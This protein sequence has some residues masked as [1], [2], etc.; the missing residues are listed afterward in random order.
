MKPATGKERKLLVKLPSVALQDVKNR[1]PADSVPFRK[2]LDAHSSR[3]VFSPYLRGEFRGKLCP[4]IRNANRAVCSVFSG[5]I[6][7]VLNVSPQKVVRGIAARWVVA[8]VKHEKPH[9]NRAFAEHVG[10]AIRTKGI[11]T[12]V[13]CPISETATARFPRPAL[14]RAFALNQAPE[15]A[16]IFQADIDRPIGDEYDV[17]SILHGKFMLMCQSRFAADYS[18]T[19]C[20]FVGQNREEVNRSLENKIKGEIEA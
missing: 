11:F 12:D 10:E 14:I 3:D 16:G 5:A 6:R 4:W 17:R 1:C 13:E 19:A 2:F 15:S 9:W 7:G 18:A 8:S 20:L